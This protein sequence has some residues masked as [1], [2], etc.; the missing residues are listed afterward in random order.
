LEEIDKM[1]AAFK[2][3]GIALYE[4]ASNLRSTPDRARKYLGFEPRG[5]SLWDTLEADLPGTGDEFVSPSF[6]VGV[7]SRARGKV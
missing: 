4:Y 6:D 5:P 7:A 1:M 2:V 3:P